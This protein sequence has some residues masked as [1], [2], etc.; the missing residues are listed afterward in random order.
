MDT[1]G[2]ADRLA[3]FCVPQAHLTVGIAGGPQLTVSSQSNRI[4]SRVVSCGDRQLLLIRSEP[5]DLII[6]RITD[7]EQT[8][9]VRSQRHP[10]YRQLI[11]VAKK[12][13]GCLLSRGDIPDFC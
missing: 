2:S 12:P 1:Q 8:P 7:Q 13:A 3:S 10:L 9:A 11:A 6:L 4:Y 5:C